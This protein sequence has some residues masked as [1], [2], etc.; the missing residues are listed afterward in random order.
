[1]GPKPWLQTIRNLKLKS[2]DLQGWKP[3][4]YKLVERGEQGSC[5]SLEK[6]L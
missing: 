2:Q 5:R 4:Y 1:M 6:L 3:L